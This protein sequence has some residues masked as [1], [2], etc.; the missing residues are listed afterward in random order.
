MALI[1][2]TTLTNVGDAASLGVCVDLGVGLGRWEC[3]CNATQARFPHLLRPCMC[4]T[5]RTEI[6]PGKGQRPTAS[7]SHPEHGYR[8]T[9]ELVVWPWESWRSSSGQSCAAKWLFKLTQRLLPHNATLLTL[10]KCHR[11]TYINH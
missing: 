8:R 4:M 9:V 5:T 3:I 1:L 10:A 11:Y 6:Q 2:T 7:S